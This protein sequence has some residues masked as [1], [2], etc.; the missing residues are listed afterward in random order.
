MMTNNSDF[1]EKS[2]KNHKKTCFSSKVTFKKKKKPP[3]GMLATEV[4]AGDAPKPSF[5]TK[6]D[7]KSKKS[8]NQP[9]NRQKKKKPYFLVWILFEKVVPETQINHHYF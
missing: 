3:A 9:L 2:L 8:G 5:S 4:R 1:N 7:E 6:I